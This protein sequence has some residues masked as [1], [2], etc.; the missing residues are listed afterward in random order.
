LP[1]DDEDAEPPSQVTL[2]LVVLEADG[3]AT[4][5]LLCALVSTA[6]REQLEADG[7]SVDAEVARAKAKRY[8]LPA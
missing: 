4:D 8:R 6:D 5:P 1:N 3:G 7:V 2:L